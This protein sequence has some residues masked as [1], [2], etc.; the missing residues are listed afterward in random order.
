MADHPG[1]YPVSGQRLQVVTLLELRA[2]GKTY[3][4]LVDL[5]D[6][7]VIEDLSIPLQTEADAYLAKY[8]RLE[9][10]LYER[11]QSLKDDDTIPRG[12]LDGRRAGTDD[13]WIIKRRLSTYWLPNIR[14]L[15]RQ[16]NAPACHSIWRR[17][18]ESLAGRYT[19]ST[20]I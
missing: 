16:W 1:S 20:S 15:P 17:R 7:S 3:Q 8:G 10:A 6:Y 2:Q 13:W 11:L 18:I 4:L 12:D 14:R 9:V 5:D 19:G